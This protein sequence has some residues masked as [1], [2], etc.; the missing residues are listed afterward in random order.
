V[1]TPNWRAFQV[2]SNFK[3]YVHHS[4]IGGAIGFRMTFDCLRFAIVGEWDKLSSA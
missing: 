4:L 3:S 2:L 1:E